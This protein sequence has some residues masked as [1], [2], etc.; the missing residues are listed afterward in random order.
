MKWYEEDSTPIRVFNLKPETRNSKPF[1]AEEVTASLMT[2]PE[3]V[4]DRSIDPEQEV[5]HALLEKDCHFRNL[6]SGS[7][8]GGCPAAGG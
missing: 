5:V 4:Y 7:P 2:G 3:G 6:V 8:A 1:L